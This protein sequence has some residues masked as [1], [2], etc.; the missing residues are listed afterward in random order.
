[1]WNAL[2][3][4]NILSI[5]KRSQLIDDSISQLRKKIIDKM[6]EQLKITNTHWFQVLR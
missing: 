6:C 4:S 5:E 1:M 3:D 2:S